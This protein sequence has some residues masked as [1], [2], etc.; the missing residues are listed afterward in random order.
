MQAMSDHGHNEL[1][2]MLTTEG[3]LKEVTEPIKDA[4]NWLT[5]KDPQAEASKKQAEGDA[6]S[7]KG[8]GPSAKEHHDD[9][10]DQDEAAQDEEET[11]ATI[12]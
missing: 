9:G 2:K 5:G 8:G 6:G 10:N 4:V 3:P 1:L 11:A 12:A 7:F